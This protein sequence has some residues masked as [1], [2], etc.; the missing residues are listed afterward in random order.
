MREEPAQTLLK[1][2]TVNAT[3]RKESTARNKEDRRK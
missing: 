3:L 2:Q 1:N